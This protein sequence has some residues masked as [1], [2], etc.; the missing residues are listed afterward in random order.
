MSATT[1]TPAKKPGNF[2]GSFFEQLKDTTKQEARSAVTAVADTIV[3]RQPTT[4]NGRN[5]ASPEHT[6][7][8]L[9]IKRRSP[10]VQLFSFRERQE[11]IMIRDEVKK[12]VQQIKREILALER[13]QKGLLSDAARITMDALPEKPGIYHIRF[14]EWVLRTIHDLRIKVSESGNWFAMLSGK[15]SKMGYHGMAKKHGTSFT[16]SGE[17][18]VS[19]SG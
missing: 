12:L 1:G 5:P 4:E 15:R 17:R 19:Q 6:Q 13:N 8:P 16:M 9:E 2:S 18:S 3:N 11:T 14:L 7:R 10:D